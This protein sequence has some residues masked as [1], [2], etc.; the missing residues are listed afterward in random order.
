MYKSHAC[1]AGLRTI[2]VGFKATLE[3]RHERSATDNEE[4]TKEKTGVWRAWVVS[5]LWVGLLVPAGASARD[6]GDCASLVRQGEGR[7]SIHRGQA[8]LFTAHMGTDPLSS[9]SIALKTVTWLFGKDWSLT[10][11]SAS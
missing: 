4:L 5:G 3:L 8:R 9:Q 2:R 7:L 6:L 10:Q 1:R 11:S